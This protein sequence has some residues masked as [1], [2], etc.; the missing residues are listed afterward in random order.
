MIAGLRIQFHNLTR[1][2]SLV[3]WSRRGCPAQDIEYFR[4]LAP[5]WA[6]LAPGPGIMSY[7]LRSQVLAL[8]W[9]HTHRGH[10]LSGLLFI[11]HAKYILHSFIS[12]THKYDLACSM[13]RGQSVQCAG[14]VVP[15]CM[16]VYVYRK[17][18]VASSQPGHTRPPPPH[19]YL[20][21]HLI[22]TVCLQIQSRGK[23]S[24]FSSKQ[25]ADIDIGNWKPATDVRW[26]SILFIYLWLDQMM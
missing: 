10:H 8:H 11:R 25:R 12:F 26:I 16:S 13:S 7:T 22:M 15:Q 14:I 4:H 21:T 3:T 17:C 20:S 5:A 9:R 19:I 6:A 18:S 24:I 2:Q 1:Y 23:I